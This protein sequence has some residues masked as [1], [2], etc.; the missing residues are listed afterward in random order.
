MHT[1]RMAQR[2]RLRLIATVCAAAIAAVLIPA[3]QFA[4]AHVIT[5]TAAAVP[6]PT[7]VLEHGAW[8]D[9]GSW[10]AVVRNL[11]GRGYTAN[12]PPNLLQGLSYDSAYLRDL[13]EEH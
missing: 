9:S 8:A 10:N 5:P 6:K 11:R 3:S 13:L 12:A 7:I 1:T 2:R 4:S